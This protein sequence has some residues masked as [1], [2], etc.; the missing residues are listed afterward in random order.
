MINL[1]MITCIMPRRAA[2][3]CCGR[4]CFDETVDRLINCDGPDGC[5]EREVVHNHLGPSLVT[6]GRQ[7]EAVGSEE[8]RGRDFGHGDPRCAGAHRADLPRNVVEDGCP[9]AQVATEGGRHRREQREWRY[10]GDHHVIG[11]FHEVVNDGGDVVT[12]LIG[13]ASAH[14]VV[15]AGQEHGKVEVLAEL[16]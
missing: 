5:S 16:R 7:V 2:P 11:A 6:G 10:T 15:A 9:F 4:S 12:P 13:A 14:D 8:V 1:T 3:L